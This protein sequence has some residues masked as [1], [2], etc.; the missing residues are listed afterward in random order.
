MA[1]IC[2]I[3]VWA[4]FAICSSIVVCFAQKFRQ[5]IATIPVSRNGLITHNPFAGGFDAPIPAFERQNSFIQATR[6]ALA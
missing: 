5:E 3:A 1:R 6:R 4:I 2:I